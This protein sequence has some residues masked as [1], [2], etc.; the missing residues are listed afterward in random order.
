VP[1]YRRSGI[2]TALLER[3]A[4]AARGYGLRAL[5]LDTA[6]DN[7]PARTLYEQ[8]G[9]EVTERRAPIDGLP[10]IVGYVRTLP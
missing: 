3:A 1:R 5:A 9:F 6:S 10:G 8:L 4:H 2:A 7:A